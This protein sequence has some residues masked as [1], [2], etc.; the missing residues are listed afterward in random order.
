MIAQLASAKVACNVCGAGPWEPHKPYCPV[1][2]DPDSMVFD[3]DAGIFKR[4]EK[5]ADEK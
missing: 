3:T 2:L 1:L 4:K 5:D